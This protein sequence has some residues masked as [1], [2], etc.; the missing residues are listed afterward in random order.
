M[1]KGKGNKKKTEE[2]KTI[3]FCQKG[4][5]DKNKRHKME[6]RREEKGKQGNKTEWEEKTKFKTGLSGTLSRKNSKI[7]WKLP[8]LGFF[9]TIKN[10]NTKKKKTPKKN[11][12]KRH[13]YT[14]WQTTP[15]IFENTIKI[16]F[17]AEHSFCVSQIVNSP[18]EAPSHNSTFETKKCQFGSSPVPAETPIFVVFG[19][20]VWIQKY[21]I[22]QKTDSCNKNARFFF[23]FRTQIPLWTQWLQY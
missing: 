10:K 7:A 15:C 23:T 11:K 18:F 12:Q 5:M 2:I 22:F 4:L 13:L 19:D 20:F 16:V 1:N 21:A 14:C 17:S 8:F 6:F 3:I 9:Q